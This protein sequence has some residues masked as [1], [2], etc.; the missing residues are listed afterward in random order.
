MLSNQLQ[1][2]QN[3]ELLPGIAMRWENSNN[4]RYYTVIVQQNLFSEWEVFC[5]WGGIG[6]R[7][8]NSKVFPATDLNDAQEKRRHLAIR[9]RQRHYH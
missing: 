2:Q 3:D 4:R 5:I 6:T 9:R 8:G 7:R 1:T